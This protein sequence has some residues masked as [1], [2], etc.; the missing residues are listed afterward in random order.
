MNFKEFVS[1]TVSDWD[2]ANMYLHNLALPVRE[3]SKRSGR[4]I[5]EIYR[6]VNRI[7]HSANRQ[8][9]NHENVKMFANGGMQTSKI[10]ELTGYTPRNVRYIL[11]K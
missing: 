11:K 3:I 8:V 9:L 4:S 6:I 10:A 5:G 1:N 7:G 2:V